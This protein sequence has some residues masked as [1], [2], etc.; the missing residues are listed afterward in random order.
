MLLFAVPAFALE[1]PPLDPPARLDEL[2][3]PIALYPDRLLAQ[4]L[5]AAT[6]HDQIPEA[7][8][9]ADQHRE[10]VGQALA[11]AMQAQRLPWDP[12]VQAMLPFPSVLDRMASRKDWTAN[13]GDAFLAHQPQVMDAI[14]RQR[15][16]AKDFGYL[17]SN[18]KI[19]VSLDHDIAILPVNPATIAVPSYDPATVFAP[20]R[21]GSAVDQAV[22]WGEGVLVG[23]FQPYGWKLEKFAVIGGYFQAWGWGLEDIDWA[24]HTMIIND[25]PWRRNWANRS[26]YAHPYPALQ[27]VVPPQ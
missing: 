3:A 25:V 15:Q 2:V 7:A 14:Q 16:K 23:G 4:V 26:E 21:P 6:F 19:A 1:A 5:A 9:W 27:K 13:L 10:L 11:L 8:H 22:G 12:G 20:P 18:P 17:R 24:A